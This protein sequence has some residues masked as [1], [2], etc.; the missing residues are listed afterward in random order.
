MHVHSGGHRVLGGTSPRSSWLRDWHVYLWGF[1]F[2]PR[3]HGRLWIAKHNSYKAQTKCGFSLLWSGWALRFA[4]WLWIR[5]VGR[6]QWCE[7]LF[8]YLVQLPPPRTLHF[9]HKDKGKHHLVQLCFWVMSSALCHKALSF[10]FRYTEWRLESRLL[11][12]KYLKN[13]IIADTGRKVNNGI[14]LQS[15]N[16][17]NLKSHWT[18]RYQEGLFGR[19]Q[20]QTKQNKTSQYNQGRETYLW[21]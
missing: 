8:L 11:T 4:I 16:A 21:K 19:W 14:T 1:H 15:L 3:H 10:G 6:E 17:D 2:Q 7:I 5:G 18:D 9:L 13:L 20:N 12:S